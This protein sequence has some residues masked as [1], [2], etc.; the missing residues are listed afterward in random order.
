[1]PHSSI[2][3]PFFPGSRTRRRDRIEREARRR[4]RKLLF[5][6][7]EARRL[8]ATV[9][10]QIAHDFDGDGQL[11]PIEPGLESWLIYADDNSDLAFNYNDTN[12]NRQFDDGIDEALEPY[13]LSDADGSYSLT[14]LPAGPHSIAQVDQTGWQQT[15][16]PGTGR[17]T[18]V[19][20]TDQELVNVTFANQRDFTPFEPGNI[21]VNRSSFIENDLL[22]EYTPNG[23]LVQALV[24]PGSEDDSDVIAKDLVLDSQRRLQ[25]FNG[26][27]D[28][29]LTTLGPDAALDPDLV[30]HWKFDET[31]GIT[32]EDAGLD[33]DN[34]G[35]LLD[36][37]IF[38]NGG[39]RTDVLELDGI[40]A[41]VE[42]DAVVDLTANWTISSWFWGLANGTWKTLTGGQN[43]DRQIVVDANGQLGSFDNAGSTGFYDSGFN[44]NGLSTDWHHVCVVGTGGTTT[45]YVDGSYA[46]EVAYQSTGDVSSLGNDSAGDQTFAQFIDDLRIYD[47]ALNATEISRLINSPP[48]P[49]FSDTV[50]SNWDMGRTFSQWG[51]IAAFGDFIFANEH[52]DDA[53]TADG[54]IRFNVSDLSY[55]RFSNGLGVPT[56]LTVGL[57]GLL[58]SLNA[59]HSNTTIRAHDPVTM[60]SVRTTNVPERLHSIAVDAYGNVYGITDTG[61]KHFGLNGDTRITTAVNGDD[62]SLSSGEFF[63]DANDNGLYDHAEEF[64][65][66][67]GNGEYDASEDFVD[68]NDNGWYDR[69]EVFIDANGDGQYDFG[70]LLLASKLRIDVIATDFDPSSVVS[71]GLPGDGATNFLAFAAFV[72]AP[73]GQSQ[74]GLGDEEFSVFTPGNI[75]VSNSPLTTGDPKLMEY[76]PFGQ[77]VQEYDIPVFEAGGARDLVMDSQADVRIYDGTFAPQ[78]STFDPYVIPTTGQARGFV[79][80]TQFDGWSTANDATFGGIAATGEFVFA[81]DV[82]TNDDTTAERGIVRYN[83]DTDTFERFHSEQGDIIDLNIGLDGL[84]YALGPTADTTGTT[85]HKYHPVT[86]ELLGE[87]TLPVSHRAIAVD[88]NGDIFAV[89]PDIHRYDADGLPQGSPLDAEEIV[90][91]SDIDVDLDGRLLIAAS[92]GHILMTDRNFTGLFTFQTRQSDGQNFAAFV[93][94]TRGTTKAN[95]DSFT[96]QEDSLNNELDV[97]GNDTKQGLGSLTI[98]DEISQPEY[99]IVRRLG[100]E[101]IS[102]TPPRDFVGVDT[103]TY[104]ISDGMGGTDKAVVRITVEGTAHFFA[105]DDG[106]WTDEDGELIEPAATGLL[107]NDGQLDIFPVLTPGNI[108]VTHSPN[109][110]G[111]KALLQEYTRTGVLVHSIE[112]PDFTEGSYADVRDVVLDYSGNVQIFNGTLTPRLTTYD[113]VA[114][115]LINKPFSNW[116]TTQNNTVGGLATWR[117]FVFATDQEVELAGDHPVLHEGIIRFDIA[118][119]T[120]QRFVDDGDFIDLAVGLDE[121]LYA[122]G[123]GSTPTGQY[124]RVY[125]PSDMTL[126]REIQIQRPPGK[127]LANILAITVDAAGNIY[128]VMGNDPIVYAFDRDGQYIRQ[129]NSGLGSEALFSDIDIHENGVDLLIANINFSNSPSPNDGDVI[130][131]DTALLSFSSPLQAPDETSDMKFVGWVQPPVGALNGPLVISSFTQPPH[132]IVDVLPDGS[133]T[134]TPA[135]EYSGQDSFTYVVQNADRLQRGATV[136]IDVRPQNDPPVLTAAMPSDLAEEDQAYTIPLTAIINGDPGTTTITD[137]D[138]LDPLGGIA[139]TE[140]TGPGRWS[141][142]TAGS[143]FVDVDTVSD[144]D[145]LLLPFDAE[146]RFTPA[147]GAGGTATFTYRAWDT[148]VGVAGN[149]FDPTYF[150]CYLGGTLLFAQDPDADPLQWCELGV[151]PNLTVY[152]PDELVHE[153]FSEEQDTLTLT[154]ADLND[155]PLLFPS[156]PTMGDTNEHDEFEIAIVDFVTGVSDPDGALGVEGIALVGSS[157]N[158]EWFYSLDGIDFEPLP[159]VSDAAALILDAD[160][161][162]RYKPDKENGE[163][164][165]V[166]YRAWDMSDSST[167][168]D[169]DVDVRDNGGVEAFSAATDTG[170]LVVT[171]VNDRPELSPASPF[172]GITDVIT[173]FIVTLDAFVTGIGD[174]DHDAV[175]GGIAITA[176][177]GNGTWA[178]STDGFNFTDMPAVSDVSA[179]LLHSNDRLRYTP[180]GVDTETATVTYV[181]WDAT[182][183]VAG[184]PSDVTPGGDESAFSI[185][186]DT[187]RLTVQEVNAPPT[188]GEPSAPV[189]Y[190]ENDPPAPIFF[191][192]TVSDP[193]SPDFDGGL[194]TVAILNGGTPNDRLSVG[195]VGAIQ[196]V[197]DNVWFNDGS[198]PELIGTVT[199]DGWNLYVNLVSIHTTNEAVEALARAIT[200]ENVS[201]DPLGGDRLLWLTI[202]DG[203]GGDDTANV[204]QTISVEPVNDPPTVAGEAYQVTSGDV[205]DVSFLEGVLANDSDFEGD[206]LTAILD[207][208]TENGDLSFNSDGSFTYTPAPL[209]YGLDTFTYTADDGQAESAIITVAVDVSLPPT[210]PSHP[211][212][213]NGDGYLSPLDPLLVAN[214]VALNGPG[215]APQDPPS[216]YDVNGDGLATDADAEMAANVIDAQGAREVPPPR[217][218]FPQ[219]PPVLGFD[220][221]VRIRMETTDASGDPIDSVPAGQPFFLDVLVSDQ[222][223]TPQGVYAAYLDVGY[224]NVRVLPNGPI[225]FGNGFPN[226]T[227]GDVSTSP[228]ID[229]VGAGTTDPL[230]DGSEHLLFRMPFMAET[231]GEAVFMG[232]PADELPAGQVLLFGIDGPIP[233]ENVTYLA[234]AITV[235]GPPDA[236]DDA[237]AVTEGDVLEVL[238]TADGVLDNDT[239]DEGDSLTAAPDD[240]PLHGSLDL[241][242]DGTFTYTP[243]EN[244]FGTDQ[245][246]YLANDGFF[247]STPATVV[248]TVTGEDDLPIAQDDR[249]GVLKD[250]VLTVNAA[251]GILANDIDVDEDGL[252]VSLPSLQ[253]PQHGDLQMNPNGSFVYTPDPGFGGVDTFTYRANDGIQ[254]SNVAIVEIDV[255][256]G[257]QNPTHAIDINGDGFASAIDPLLVFNEWVRSR[258]DRL[259]PSPPEPPDAPPPFYDYNGDG[260]MSTFDGQAALQEL[261]DSGAGQL[262][263]PRLDLPQD[264][265][266]LPPG[267]LVSF[268][269][270]T[271][272][273]AGNPR[274]EFGVGETFYLNVFVED[275]RTG[276]DGVFSAYLDVGYYQTGMNTAGSLEYGNQFPNVQAGNIQTPGLLDEVGA[277]Q[278]PATSGQELLLSGQEL[279]LFRVAFTG[280]EVG[281]HDIVANAADDLPISDTTLAGIDGPIPA[282]RIVYGS[283]AV[284]V[285]VADD[286][287]DGVTDREEDDAPNGGDGNSD[288]TSDKLQSNVASLANSVSGQYVTFAA[289]AQTA[290]QNVQAIDNPSPADVPTNVGFGLGFFD[291]DLTQVGAGG[292][293]VVTTLLEPGA[294]ANTYYRYGPTPDNPTPHWYP[295]IFD[296]STGAKV[297]GDRIEIHFVDGARGD[298][299]LNTNGVIVGPGGLGLVATPWQNPVLHEDVNNDGAVTPLDALLLIGAI[300]ANGVRGLP[301]IPEG[302]DSIPPYWDVNGDSS[303]SSGDV[304]LVI[305]VLNDIIGG[306]GEASR[307]SSTMSTEASTL[308]NVENSSTLLANVGFVSAN[309]TSPAVFAGSASA[310]LETPVGQSA[311]QR[312]VE[313]MA[314]R[315]IPN[316]SAD[317]LAGRTSFEDEDSNWLLSESDLE[318]ALADIAGEISDVWS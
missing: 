179:L 195:D 219:D 15:F 78:L 177:F 90:G 111:Q 43:G 99:G 282:D 201:E 190:A 95:W 121:F 290:F 281:Q 314:E 56:D 257:W 302:N 122:L 61:L 280:T 128:A 26:Y 71:F 248:I 316:R 6:P 126:D 67:N 243:D 17:H 89:N 209:Y 57:D 192:A 44:M 279:L 237:Y 48:T 52:M 50:V 151:L 289:P 123:P 103:F 87:I 8:L 138:I 196:A 29:R 30:G 113:P 106:Y 166:T 191:D 92:D 68:A 105:E 73:V 277:V 4:R 157:G 284:T 262:A 181:A 205:L 47:R 200:Y 13:D 274:A 80:H 231:R 118:T 40:D 227:S 270:E 144:D 259:L 127:Q 112:L 27:D 148:T 272:D 315:P 187:A 245:F 304:L 286:D 183:G 278:S 162:V 318:D 178:Y 297:Y 184:T 31:D 145:A 63:V 156:A 58:Y 16:P 269:L 7:L 129:G 107:I 25:I 3:G 9:S 223:I 12:A 264:S 24:I 273:A 240:G 84:L 303:I 239:D 244:F 206:S 170:R 153:E 246:T 222:R 213:V 21:L 37:A 134:Y 261:D 298:A 310:T 10:G 38:A 185:A 39:G 311:I 163:E 147:G 53:G 306:E 93:S 136:T 291:F 81:T 91:L 251:D 207:N 5:E 59:T 102:Y 312:T 238:D 119:Q 143:N 137:L 100:T 20:T 233:E 154:L 228:L 229:E 172:L 180:N 308:T 130:L 294:T 317:T 218:E 182:Q 160:D 79:S 86:M 32:A 2:I 197:G 161:I 98:T 49:S 173:P 199:V 309:A 301:L 116:N 217:L 33:G 241:N 110:V 82:R 247:D 313:P 55:E 124:I 175:V 83:V 266:V 51:D 18:V 139:V 186:I 146:I 75:L 194:L 221:F 97:L 36:G 242:S 35:T 96:V 94:P 66:A 158:G 69:A 101:A 168:G 293:A 54:V 287:G 117:N 202:A 174:I 300:N 210:N 268:R 307:D 62:I 1:M 88:A 115:V 167:A 208:P 225:S 214:Y 265:P 295:F 198:G 45:F 135:P 285:T 235:T 252:T 296:G 132:G 150:D 85:V 140:V 34:A 131:T 76:T 204:T 260:V 104:E 215:P 299:D 64:D 149:K 211:V 189:Q 263:E 23:E 193:T 254:D 288:S 70:K 236:V 292:S 249:Y 114:G 258:G 77:L 142:S 188:I 203:D 22:I 60:E 41:R 46:G 224:D 19:V 74:G 253:G 108:L 212:D 232:D 133:F 164:A 125:D 11:E 120:A 72:Q 256:F 283:T 65:D 171:D 276:G 271:T 275:L 176:T 216:F 226:F 159:D 305:G 155:A 141:Y 234:T 255:L 169:E 220:E 267:D 14:D 28:V 109:G 165:S 42:L 250:G 152:L 230:A